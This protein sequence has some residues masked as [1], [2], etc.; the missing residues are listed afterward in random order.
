MEDMRPAIGDAAQKCGEEHEVLHAGLELLG[1]LG[2]V[3]DVVAGTGGSLE[4]FDRV[5]I[6]GKG[7]ESGQVG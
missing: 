3:K 5:R 4:C 7:G 2:A 1:T 6:H